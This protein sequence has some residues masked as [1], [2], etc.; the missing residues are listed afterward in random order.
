MSSSKGC[1]EIC[2]KS[3]A[4][5]HRSILCQVCNKHLHIKCNQTDAKTFENIN[6]NKIPQTC[7]KCQV[8]GLPFQDLSDT[9]FSAENQNIIL[10]SSIACKPQCKICTK[11][12]AKNH[13]KISCQACSS[14]VH[15]KCNQTDVKT[16]N[17]ILKEK[18]PQTCLSCQNLH[19]KSIS[20]KSSC[21]VCTKTIAKNH[22]NI[23]CELCNC[24]VHI[25]CNKTDV[26]TYNSVVKENKKVTCISCQLENIPFQS[27]TDIEF[28]AVNKGLDT[29]IFYKKSV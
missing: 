9:Q 27:L 7:L 17:K 29:Q 24:R 19:T 3:I 1:C 20:Q 18:L 28:S 11:T 21:G 15:I 5:N 25:K 14:N 6:R 16:Y 13:R 26:K 22:Q 4:I 23:Y 2:T 8:K 10:P 12:I